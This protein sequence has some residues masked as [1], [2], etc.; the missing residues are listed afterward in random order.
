MLSSYIQ[1][2]IIVNCFNF[3]EVD[4]MQ[5]TKVIVFDLDGTLYEDTH[6]FDYYA[7][8]LC[9]KLDVA[10]RP[11]FKQDYEAVLKGSHPLKMG[12]V[13]DVE[14]DLILNQKNGRVTQARTWEG[15][16]LLTDEIQTIYNSELQFNFHSMLNIGDLWWVP[17]A[18]ARHYGIDNQSAEASFIETR[19]YMMSSKFQ[20]KEVHGLKDTLL[21][22]SKNKRLILLTNSPERDSEVI[23]SKLGFQEFF[24]KKIFDGR[25]PI[26]TKEHLMR[27]REQFQVE[28]HQI[29]SI[30]DNAIN[31]ITPA[32]VL[33]CQTILIDPHKISKPSDADNILSNLEE[34]VHILIKL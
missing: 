21:Q 33:G 5:N 3:I 13:F 30:G 20:M 4:E 24:H 11:L 12:T 15:Q 27:I 32:K 6:H 7:K 18:I 1:R 29:L 17:A 22:L 9:E 34:L 23:L 2:I 16:S 19:E 26:Q 10:K 8:K 31:E 14:K 25:K 28:Y